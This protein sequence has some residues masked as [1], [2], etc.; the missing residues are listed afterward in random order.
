LADPLSKFVASASRSR[1]PN[2]S[3]H[4]QAD[5]APHRHHI[6]QLSYNGR[7]GLV[8]SVRPT[9]RP[10]RPALA[11]FRCVCTVRRPQCW[12]R[13]I[14]TMATRLGVVLVCY[15]NSTNISKRPLLIISAS[16]LLSFQKYNPHLTS[17]VGHDPR[18]TLYA[19][20]A[21]YTTP[22]MIV[23]PSTLSP[24]RITTSSLNSWS[25]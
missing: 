3:S 1:L 19:Y 16:D 4:H 7:H 15:T 17:P 14:F 20:T 2:C 8:S 10:F 6:H 11:D 13:A 5:R 9:G 12:S 25:A 22:T 24:S 23:V 18:K 21:S